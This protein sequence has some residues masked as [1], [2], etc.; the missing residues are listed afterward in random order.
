MIRPRTTERKRH[1]HDANVVAKIVVETVDPVKYWG[2][3]AKVTLIRIPANAICCLLKSRAAASAVRP[4][5]VMPARTP[6][7]APRQNGQTLHQCSARAAATSTAKISV[8]FR[9]RAEWPALRRRRWIPGR[10]FRRISAPPS[11]SIDTPRR[12]HSSPRMER[13]SV[14]STESKST[15]ASATGSG[16]AERTSRSNA[17]RTSL[18]D[19]RSLDGATSFAFMSGPV[20]SARREVNLSAD[21][22]AY[23]FERG[24]TVRCVG[25]THASPLP[26][27]AGVPPRT[28]AAPSLS[29]CGEGSIPSPSG[30]GLGRGSDPPPVPTTNSELRHYSPWWIGRSPSIQAFPLPVRPL[31]PGEG[32]EPIP[33]VRESASLSFHFSLMNA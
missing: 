26:K 32:T 31:P 18:P 5:S 27:M 30:G 24:A 22:M 28:C 4:R 14:S 3:N 12:V 13:D 6:Y 1:P 10:I 19:I 25:A 15:A 9:C 23:R 16:A 11:R 7:D 33:E 29:K 20:P 2:K 21:P 8:A 17:S